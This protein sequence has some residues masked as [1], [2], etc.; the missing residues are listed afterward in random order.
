M[1][2]SKSRRVFEV[3]E[4]FADHPGMVRV[5][6]EVASFETLKIFVQFELSNRIRCVGSIKEC[7]TGVPELGGWSS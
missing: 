3:V 1:V 2:V 7:A 5:Y 6:I 4:S